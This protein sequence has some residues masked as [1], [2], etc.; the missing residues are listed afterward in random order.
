MNEHINKERETRS[1]NTVLIAVSFIIF[2]TLGIIFVTQMELHPGWVWEDLREVYPVRIQAL[3]TD[4]I[5]G[6]GINHILVYADISRGEERVANNTPQYGGVFL[7]SGRNSAVIWKKEFNT[8][9]KRVFQI[10]DANSDGVR[11]FLVNRAR[12]SENWTGFENNEIDILPNMTINHLIS[13]NKDDNGAPIPILT[14]DG[15]SFTNLS[16]VD[17]VSFNN[18]LDNKPDFL[19]LEGEYVTN[20][21]PTYN[22]TISSYFV[23][24]TRKNST[25]GGSF[26]VDLKRPFDLPA[27][28]L[29][30]YNGSSQLLFLSG[31]TIKLFNLS[32]TNYLDEIYSNPMPGGVRSYKIVEDLTLDEIPE[33][34][35]ISDLNQVSLIN[36]SNG[37]IIRSF[38]LPYEI[39]DINVYEIPT[40]DGDGTILCM[41]ESRKW[42]SGEGVHYHYF[43]I[44][45]IELSSQ[46]LEWS[47]SST[48]EH[49]DLGAIVLDKD[50][51]GDSINEIVY[52]QSF[53]PFGAMEPISR[54]KII[55]FKTHEVFGIFNIEYSSDSML[56]IDDFDRDG[57][58]D[59]LIINEE[60]I[61]ALSAKKPIGIWLSTES[62]LGMPLFIAL[63]VILGIGVILLIIKSRDLRMSRKAIRASIKKTK[64]TIMVNAI[65]L[66][67]MT[68]C[69]I[70]F[71]IQLNIFNNTLISNHQMTSLIIVFISVIILWYTILP[72]TAAVYNQFAP[73][74]AFLFIKL[75]NLFFKM[76]R[77]YNHE[78]I[79]VDM[80]DRKEINIVT[81]IKRV[82]LPLLLSITVG[83]YIYN[84]FAPIMGFSQGFEQFGSTEFFSFM[85]GYMQM[86]LLPIILSYLLF[87][88]FIS[89]GYLCDD[90]GIVYY[91][92]S[93]K[94]RLPGD[95]E[96]ISIWSQSM[97]KGVA[98]LSALITFGIFFQQVDF[99]GFFQGNNAL[100]L[101]FGILIVFVMFWGAPF[102]TGF[103]YILLTGEIME[104]SV[105]NNTQKLYKMMEKKGY[106]TKPHNLTNLYPSGYN[107]SKRESPRQ[108]KKTQEKESE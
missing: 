91:K 89:G 94:Y 105:D 45:S 41:L 102:L 18:I 107:P 61:V 66:I 60:R 103:S 88:F 84:T 70:L 86:C 54:Y 106:D 75:R 85:I 30:N 78:I 64:L 50:F 31:D 79:V 76:S 48:S 25:F 43:E 33:I 58:R 16:I 2:G 44:Y 98:G 24:G 36:G 101:I 97:V 39:E 22:W 37:N 74:F 59:F 87:S 82:I 93:K 10:M 80:K 51:D 1:I 71:L 69:F 3:E 8:P 13:G 53:L 12:V 77:G 49:G 42:D 26:Y 34:L 17:L 73:Q 99:S 57:A 38:A 92:E 35:I 23:N 100:F 81:R 47:H 14:G 104:Y 56:T 40:I 63:T 67:L 90:A 68:L 20:P 32:S 29:L 72:L 4:D 46:F 15:I 6:D 21:F 62:G 83:F 11:D 9:V 28:D 7:L 19:A 108:I 27:I 65:V 96:P 52:S 5:N 55:S 95:I